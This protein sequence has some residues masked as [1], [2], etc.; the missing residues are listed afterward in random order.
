MWAIYRKELGRFFS[1]L[2]GYVIIGTFLLFLG[3]I[4]F[5]FPTYS[6]LNIPVATLDP[7]FSIA[8]FVF[9]FLIP[10]LTMSAFAEENQLG[11]FEL[12]MTKPIS[13][14]SFVFSKFL[15]CVTIVV[16]AILPTILYYLTIG[17]LG[18]PPWNLDTGQIAGSYLGLMFLATTFVAIGL[19]ASTL[20]YNQIVA[21]VLGCLLCLIFY[22]GFNMLSTF[23]ALTGGLDL[24]IESLGIQSHYESIS[25]GLIDTRDVIYFISLICLF[26]VVTLISLATRHWK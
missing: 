24:F 20:T 22:W 7:L 12:L 17:S 6:I 16:F 18:S 26:L 13:D 1:S 25:R 8:P 4:L 10:A 2:T 21:F 14:F 15:A 9:L 5:V 3:M 11:T 23:G 19:F